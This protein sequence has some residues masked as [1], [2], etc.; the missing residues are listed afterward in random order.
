[1]LLRLQEGPLAIG[2]HARVRQVTGGHHR[3]LEVVVHHDVVL[4]RGREVPEQRAARASWPADTR[5]LYSAAFSRIAWPP[6]ASSWLTSP[7]GD[8][9]P[10]ALPTTC[11]DMAG[12]HTGCISS[13]VM[14]MSRPK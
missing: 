14:S 5:R 8:S 1:M 3:Q 7:A 11:S 4:A 10:R 13:A 2:R 6:R 12:A 9:L